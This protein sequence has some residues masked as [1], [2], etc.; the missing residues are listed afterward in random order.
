MK[1]L[2]FVDVH[3]DTGYFNDSKDG[4]RD[5]EIE[6]RGYFNILKE[7][8]KNADVVLCAGDFTYFGM[9]QEIILDTMNKLGKKVVLIHGN[10]EL[11]EEV[12]FDIKKC[13]NLFYIHNRYIEVEECLVL[14]FNTSGFLKADLEFEKY[15]KGVDRI[16]AKARNENK[17]VVLIA[18]GPPYMTKLDER[19]PGEHTGNKSLTDAIKKYKFDLVICGH[20]HETEHRIDKVY[21][22]VVSNP[23][24]DGEIFEV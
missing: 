21:D 20:I 22:S 14:G 18:H 6:S 4:D 23:G 2:C 19:T 7:K 15:I 10:H 16:I 13:K 1:F 9:E 8:A 12:R 5:F 3:G 24:P 11:E 17:K